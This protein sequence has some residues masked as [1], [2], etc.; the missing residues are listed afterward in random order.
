MA[1]IR[2]DDASAKTLNHIE[3]RAKQ[4]AVKNQRPINEFYDTDEYATLITDDDD[5]WEG[6]DPYDR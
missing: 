2:N 6:T 1:A 5:L 3:L 4:W